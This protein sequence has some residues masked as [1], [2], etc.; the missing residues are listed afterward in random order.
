MRRSKRSRLAISTIMMLLLTMIIVLSGGTA[1]YPSDSYKWNRQESG[2]TAPIHDVVAIDAAH[3][4]AVTGNSELQLL[5][6][7]CS[8]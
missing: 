1:A 7:N 4:W 3:V 5:F 2:T 6:F 8:S